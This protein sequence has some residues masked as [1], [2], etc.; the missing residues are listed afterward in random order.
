MTVELNQ[1]S[2][3]DLTPFGKITVIKTLVISKIVHILI[4]LPTPS[5]KVVKEINTLLYKF[6][7]S[8]KPDKIKRCISNL[9]ILKGGLNMIDLKTFDQALKLKWIS[10]YFNTSSTWKQLADSQFPQL[11]EIINYSD[12]FIE[13]IKNTTNNPFWKDVLSYLTSFVKRYKLLSRNEAKYSSFLYNSKIKIGRLEIQD[14]ILKNNHIYFIH[15]FMTEDRFLNFREF[16]DKYNININPLRYISITSSIKSF[17]KNKPNLNFEKQWEHPPPFDHILKSK[18]G[19]NLIYK[20]LTNLE[21]EQE[22]TGFLKWKKQINISKEDWKRM[23]TNLKRTTRDSKLFWLQYRINH[24]I[25]STNRSVSKFNNEQNHLCQFCSLHSETIHHLLWKCHKVQKF[26][27]KLCFLINKRCSNAHRFKFE[28]KYILFGLG[29]KIYT[30]KICD[31]ITLN[32]KF[33]IYKCKVQHIDLNID[34]FMTN[35]YYRY[36]IEKLNNH[37][38]VT[39]R[40]S[41]GPYLNLFKSLQT[42]ENVQYF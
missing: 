29:E 11:S 24:S 3:R 18:K 8:D 13:N 42:P 31:F 25:L 10:R 40:N 37:N 5:P 6:L 15:Q 41:W 1:W 19:A 2:K 32:A 23:F 28:E 17:L 39:F 22:P 35:I 33:Y 12:V 7:W 36:Q 38:S 26:W 34:T 30:D 27:Q 16:K 20:Q 9:N 14:R 4:S 21:K